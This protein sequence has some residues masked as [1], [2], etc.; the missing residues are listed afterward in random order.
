MNTIP[1]AL[2]DRENIR[3]HKIKYGAMGKSDLLMLLKKSGI[4][5]NEHADALF[6]SDRFM[7]SAVKQQAMLLE[8]SVM[9]LG[10]PGGG[11]IQEIEKHARQHGLRECPLEIAPH[12]RLQYTDQNEKEETRRN[13]APLGSV[14][15]FSK[16]LTE[17][18]DF[19][20]GFYLRRIEGELWLR[21]YVCPKDHVWSPEDR[22]VFMMD[23]IQDEE[24]TP[25]RSAG[26]D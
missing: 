6:S 26:N 13:K 21:G 11:T 14:T 4:K 12:F 20:K 24:F 1:D 3:L 22:F 8:L 16:P 19:P 7:V 23:K 25:R 18:D 5:L 15:V 9:D 10:L 2:N 17:E